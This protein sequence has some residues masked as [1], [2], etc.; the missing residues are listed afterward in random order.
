MKT[1]IS[2]TSA[3]TPSSTG[4]VTRGHGALVASLFT[5]LAIPTHRKYKA[6][7]EN[8]N[9]YFAAAENHRHTSTEHVYTHDK[10]KRKLVSRSATSISIR[11]YNHIRTGHTT[12][13]LSSGSCM[14]DIE[15][16]TLQPT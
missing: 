15:G 10:R 11:Q 1:N 5:D 2:E 4:L 16:G 6:D 12:S 13:P 3:V 14:F 7:D 9:N 8:N